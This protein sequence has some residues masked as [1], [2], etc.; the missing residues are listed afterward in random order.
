MNWLII[1]SVVL[2][3]GLITGKGPV[4]DIWSDTWHSFTVGVLP[5]LSVLGLLLLVALV[6]LWPVNLCWIVKGWMKR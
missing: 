3:I 4:K 2:V 1:G 5:W 6:V